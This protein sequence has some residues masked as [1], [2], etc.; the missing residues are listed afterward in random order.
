[1]SRRLHI[2]REGIELGVL[3]E[4][5]ADELLGAGFLLPTDLYWTDGMRD[6]KP[7]DEL[8]PQ[9]GRGN[10]GKLLGQ[11]KQTV[12][13]ARR[14]LAHGAASIVQKVKSVA[15]TGRGQIADSKRRVLEDF[16]PQIQR[17]VSKQLMG[18]TLVRAQAAVHDD[19][20]MRK[21]FGAVYDCLP[22]PVHRFV[23]EQDFL[24]FCMER[25]R[26]LLG[27]PGDKES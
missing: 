27:L 13:T 24:K 2:A 16:T 15:I 7:L 14:T 10:A 19:D 23:S 11:A 3:A 18:K 5:E 4:K 12:S 26:I 17:L 8:G 9:P 25:R 21:T 1:M 20:F 22:K 6:W